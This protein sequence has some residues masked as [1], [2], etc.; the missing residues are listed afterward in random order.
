MAPT[1]VPH[2]M[3]IFGGEPSFRVSSS[4][5]YQSTPTS[6]APRAPPPDKIIARRRLL[7]FVVVVAVMRSAVSSAVVARRRCGQRR[8]LEKGCVHGT[9]REEPAHAGVAD[10]VEQ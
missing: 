10:V 8:G 7:A 5:T 6:Y 3:S 2:R 1:L 4:K 9:L